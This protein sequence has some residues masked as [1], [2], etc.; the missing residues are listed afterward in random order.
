MLPAGTSV[1]CAEA[2]PGRK[3]RRQI[4]E[5]IGVVAF[6]GFQGYTFSHDDHEFMPGQSFFMAKTRGAG[7]RA[8]SAG[9]W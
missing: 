1:S 5:R 6:I 3:E 4:A 9:A 8:E 2:L 7:D